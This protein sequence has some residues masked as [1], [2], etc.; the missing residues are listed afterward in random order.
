MNPQPEFTAWVTKYALTLG[1]E[2]IQAMQFNSDPSLI[3]EVGTYSC[4]H[5]EGRQWHRTEVAAIERAEAM[6][7]AKIA[8]LEKQIKQIPSLEERLAR[9]KALSFGGADHG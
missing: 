7:T 9:L 2:K 1:I 4:F 6:R 8:S 5:G 3:Y